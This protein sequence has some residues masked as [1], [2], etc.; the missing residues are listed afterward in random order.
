[1]V[2]SQDITPMGLA[3]LGIDLVGDSG[4]MEGVMDKVVEGLKS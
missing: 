4:V 3:N 1:L 2:G